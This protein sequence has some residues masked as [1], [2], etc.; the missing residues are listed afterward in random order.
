ML[1]QVTERAKSLSALVLAG[2]KPAP[3]ATEPA[4]TKPAPWRLGTNG[5]RWISAISPG[6]CEA[7]AYGN[8]VQNCSAVHPT[9]PE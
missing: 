4:T 7:I 5:A 9:A 8:N 3:D 2:L 1:N 6:F